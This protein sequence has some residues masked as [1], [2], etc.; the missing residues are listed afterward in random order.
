M[1]SNYSVLL[2][3]NSESVAF[4]QQ[5]WIVIATRLI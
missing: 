5:Q 1:L 2:L 4:P 3:G